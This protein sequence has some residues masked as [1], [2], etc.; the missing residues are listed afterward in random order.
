[1]NARLPRIVVVAGP[2]G[3]GKSDLALGLAERLGGEIVGADSIQLYRHLDIGSAKPTVAERARIP[4]HLVDR[5][6]PR[7]PYTAADFADDAARAIDGILERGARPLVVG[8]TLLYQRALVYGICDAPGE[9]AGIRAELARRAELEGW[10]ALHA[11]LERRDPDAAAKIHPNDRIRIERALE[12]LESGGRAMSDRQR[13]HASAPPRYETLEL[14]VNLPREQLYRR[15]ERRVD[16]MIDAGW[17]G[18]VEAL[19][20]AGYDPAL[21][22]LQAIGYRD[23][24][25]CL[26]GEIDRDEAVRRIR[27]DTR[28]FAKRQLTWLRR[29][30]RVSWYG[31][32]A[33]LAGE[34]EPAVRRFFEGDDPDLPP[35][36]ESAKP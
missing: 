29:S 20:A 25:A 26:R 18:E 22:P 23:V 32:R 35:M 27:R 16:A 13:E 1:M 15:I 11:E 3:V 5:I 36:D 2:T 7:Q 4:H 9:V 31:P 10:P 30:P 19:L 33:G 28:R 17:F 24:V 8:G 14:G 34:L 21:K 6:D 12:V